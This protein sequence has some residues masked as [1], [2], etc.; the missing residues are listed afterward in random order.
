MKKG[1]LITLGAFLV[2][3]V[4]GIVAWV[5]QLAQ[6]LQLTNLNNFNTWGLYI[7]GS[8]LFTGIAAGSLLFTSSAYLFPWMEEFKPYTRISSFLGAICGVIAAGLF[9][10]VDIGNPDRAWYIIT[11]AN[12]ASP[13]FWDTLI[14]GCYII[15][16]I[17]YAR[18][19]MLLQEGKVTEKSLGPL[20]VIAFIAGLL[21]M[22]T[23]FVFAMQV[24]HPIWN[25]PVQP[26]SFLAAAIVVAL[27]L[28]IIVFAILNRSGYIQISNK[29]LGKLAKI[30]GAFLLFELFVVLGEVALGLYSAQ[31]EEG[32]VIN[33]LVLGQGAP[34]FVIEIIAIAVGVILS[35]RK[36]TGIGLA[37]T[38]AGFSLFAV[39]MI[40]YNLLQTELANPL[41]MYAG[42][43]GYNPFKLGIYIPSWIEVGIAAGII[44]LG[45]LLVVLGLNY[46][47]LGEG[48]TKG[49]LKT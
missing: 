22:V 11:S 26:I 17:V 27:S 36:S 18:Q 34:L 12:I 25:N 46:L 10:I 14:L 35:L 30:S 31:G 8:M 7:I 48:Y 44:A 1:T 28:L 32:R 43:E 24:A 39:F 33:W 47:K 40:K 13:V 6:G 41:L 49:A 37:V 3:A 4:L 19:L 45:G 23:A 21:V 38:A 5:L 29:K 20:N 16:G 2:V 42:P 15:I 9:L